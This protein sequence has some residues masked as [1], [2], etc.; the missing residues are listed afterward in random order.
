MGHLKV[1]ATHWGCATRARDRRRRVCSLSLVIFSSAE[2]LLM[3][4]SRPDSRGTPSSRSPSE[5]AGFKRGLRRVQGRF[6]RVQE[7]YRQ[8]RREV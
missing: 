8:G 7:R 2:E 3:G 6:G 1:K 5:P 4:Q